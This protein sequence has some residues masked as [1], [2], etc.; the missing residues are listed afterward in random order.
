MVYRWSV[1]VSRFSVSRFSL[2]VV[3]ASTTVFAVETVETVEMVRR[4]VAQERKRRV[5]NRMDEYM[6]WDL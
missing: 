3:V 6:F 2:M 5:R 4:W 1:V